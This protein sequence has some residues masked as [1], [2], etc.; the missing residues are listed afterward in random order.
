MSGQWGRR[1]SVRLCLDIRQRR[2]H[3]GIGPQGHGAAN[4]GRSLG[5]GAMREVGVS[6]IG[7]G[8]T[9]WR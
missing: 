7:V 3:K 2:V 6:M 9:E 8:G 5:V 1:I 4:G